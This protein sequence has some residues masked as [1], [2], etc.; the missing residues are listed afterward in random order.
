MIRIAWHIDCFLHQEV[1]MINFMEVRVHLTYFF[2]YDFPRRCQCYTHGKSCLSYSLKGNHSANLSCINYT[3][4]TDPTYLWYLDNQSSMYFNKKL[5]LK[6]FEDSR[7]LVQNHTVLET[8]KFQFYYISS[9]NL[10]DIMFPAL[11]VEYESIFLAFR[12][13]L[14]ISENTYNTYLFLSLLQ[15]STKV[16]M[17][18]GFIFQSR[19]CCKTKF[20]PSLRA[21]T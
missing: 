2:R 6:I 17:R 21:V 7:I 1:Q 12:Y 19:K 18:H 16:I 20:V 4:S 3:S 8:F 13:N 11:G 5:G 9:T 10:D 14:I 15:S